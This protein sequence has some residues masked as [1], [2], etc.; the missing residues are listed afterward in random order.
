MF[1]EKD[2]LAVNALRALSVAQIEAANSGHPGLPLG[3]APMAYALFANHL[4]VD[5]QDSQWIN[6]DRFVLSPGHGSALL[7]S[8][9]HL[10]GYPLSLEDLKAFRQ[11]GSKTPGHPEVGHTPG[12]EAT[13]GPLGQGVAQA[14][15]MAMAEQHTAAL[16]N[17]E[18]FPIID[19]YTYAIVSDGDLMEGISYEAM[20]LAGKQALDK[21][22]FL[23]DSNDISL[24]GDLHKAFIEK[25]RQR[26][27]SANW[28]YQLVEDG[29][30]LD[31]LAAAIETAKDHKGQ[32]SIIEV[33]T[34]IGF[35][36][37]EAGTNKVH[38]N[39][40]G[41]ANWQATKEAYQWDYADFEVPQAA[42]DVFQEKV[43][44]R[45]AAAHQAWQ[46]LFT[47]YKAAEPEKA[48]LLE[49]AFAGELPSDY[50]DE[51]VFLDSS[52]K[53]EA[54]RSSSGKAI[55]ALAKKVP[56]LWG[57]S[58]DLSG[59]NK[60]MISGQAD[61]MPESRQGNNIWFGVREFSMAAIV[62]G[63]LL[64]GGTKVFAST[65]F[66]FTDYLKPAVRLSALSGLPATYVMTHDSVAVGEDGPTH[67]PIEH[68]AAF[69][70]TPNLNVIRPA[71]ANETNVAWKVA[72]ES[73]H[74]PTMM[75]LSRQN[76]PILDGSQS[77]AEEG[78]RRGA[79]VLSPAEK[80]V[81]DGILIATGSEVALA[82]ETQAL[83]KEKGVD[84]AV[85]SMPAQNL[86][87]EQD[88]DYKESVLP[89]AVENR[90]SIELGSSFGWERY[91]GMTGLKIAIDTFGAS[92]PGDHVLK[93]YGFEAQQIA[94]KYLSHFA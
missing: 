40:L 41:Q 29:N 50:A 60:S 32:P 65:F 62:N 79:Y 17:T 28:H 89:S 91:V 3:V 1:K 12:V 44:Q 87:D 93:E 20:S 72:M 82:V 15:G 77:K 94:A 48:Q 11:W 55:N 34:V 21:L 81:A 16:Y 66:V 4:N 85:V 74:R 83:L 59:S 92:A 25:T 33:K 35:G 6:R 2:Y 54:S 64:H 88:A 75:V 68:L 24:D 58:A 31:A 67:E 51:M 13:T 86:F 53:A 22:I 23:Y 63:I 5:P 46:A 71:D 18:A 80:A 30:D 84:V 56:F 76:L 43:T 36:S 52:A 26:F 90:V 7:Y 8:L 61:F 37:P 78:V 47:E 45:G 69:R 73:Q 14:V 70:A 19:H 38:G 57:G 9:L 10:A 49:M 42:Y 27:E 39:P